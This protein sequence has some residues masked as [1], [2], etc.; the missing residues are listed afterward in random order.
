MLIESQT[1]SLLL[2]LHEK[3]E[4][5]HSLLPWFLASLVHLSGDVFGRNLKDSGILWYALQRS[6]ILVITNSIVSCM[7]QVWTL[8]F[9][10][11][12]GLVYSRC[13]ESKPT[14]LLIPPSLCKNIGSPHP[15][16][17]CLHMPCLCNH[18]ALEFSETILLRNPLV[19]NLFLVQSAFIGQYA[20]TVELVNSCLTL[21]K[22]RW[23]SLVQMNF[24]SFF[25]SLPS[26]F[27]MSL[28]FL[29]N[30]AQNVAILKKLQ[31]SCVDIEGL[32]S[33]NA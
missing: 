5:F 25:V 31:T 26:G 15:K 8:E 6:H 10:K 22:A 24:T 11:S 2:I 27:G 1:A 32:A 14:Q 33:W 4:N 19:M 23:C 9:H 17:I 20:M 18:S 30:F 12:T 3:R 7:L 29:I 13:N 16:E 28:N 21:L